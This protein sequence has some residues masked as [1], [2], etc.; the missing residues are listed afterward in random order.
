MDPKCWG[1]TT[2]CADIVITVLHAYI[3]AD[4]VNKCKETDFWKE[5]TCECKPC[6]LANSY[7][8][9]PQLASAPN[10]MLPLRYEL[11][12]SQS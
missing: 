1:I 9:T 11:L 12:L 3:K 8:V 10:F 5:N 4:A 2:E 7:I 6:T